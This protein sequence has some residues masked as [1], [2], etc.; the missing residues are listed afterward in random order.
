[1]EH[2]LHRQLGI[3]VTPGTPLGLIAVPDALEV[4]L[5][6]S[7]PDAERLRASLGQTVTL[8]TAIGEKTI[9]WVEK[10]EPRC[11][12]TLRAPQLGAI[13]GGS[14]T[15]EL[16][17]DSDGNELLKLPVPRFDVLIRLDT[18]P[19]EIVSA[20]ANGTQRADENSV[21]EEPALINWSPGQPV[22]VR[23]PGESASLWNAMQVWF[24]RQWDTW[25][26]QAEQA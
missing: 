19:D 11:S 20:G 26:A 15:V 23:V 25:Q 13:Y 18:P 7:Q 12:D 1:V 8:T 2:D 9:G 22:W 17:K 24:D 10:V 4:H 21:H 3:F 6:A 14:I 5:S 16:T